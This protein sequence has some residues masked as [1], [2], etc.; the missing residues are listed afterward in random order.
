[1]PDMKEFEE[2]VYNVVKNI[3]FKKV[4]SKFQEQ[5]RQDVKRIT[6]SNKGFIPADKTRN[7]Y[8]LKIK[9]MTKSY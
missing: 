1:M 9:I 4:R 6:S 2:D 8:E 7:Y 5:L 3:K